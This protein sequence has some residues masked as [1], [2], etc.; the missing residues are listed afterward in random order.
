[1]QL[2]LKDKTLN[3][4]LERKNRKTISIKITNKGEVI[5]SAPLKISI[6]QIEGLIEKKSKW[7]LLKL[8]EVSTRKVKTQRNFLEEG[9]LKFLGEEYELNIYDTFN[10][11]IEIIFDRKNFKVYLPKNIKEDRQD[12]IRLALEGWYRAKAKIIF[13]ERVRLYAEK[14]KVFPK[15]IVIKDQKTKWG[16]CSSKGNINF[17]YRVIMAPIEIID[18]LTVHELCHLIHMNHS[19]DFW[20]KVEGVLPNYKQAETWLKENGNDLNI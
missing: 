10:S 17:N 2:K 11:N 15:R 5:V 7:I 19:N 6:E 3:Y 4:T 1:M 14:L 12:Y 16:S 20:S 18:Y 9:K 13:E 8:E